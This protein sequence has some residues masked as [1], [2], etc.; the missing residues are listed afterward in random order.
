MVFK[1]NNNQWHKLQRKLSF[2][3]LCWYL[4]MHIS[5]RS[6]QIDWKHILDY[7][8]LHAKCIK[9]PRGMNESR[10]INITWSNICANER[11]ENSWIAGDD[12]SLKKHRRK[13]QM[14]MLFTVLNL[15][16]QKGVFYI[17]WALGDMDMGLWEDLFA[18]CLAQSCHQY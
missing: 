7:N 6:K 3:A 12:I 15:E 9:S 17:N 11:N 1:L 16:I 10:I 8:S 14:H 5:T 13:R 4:P 2:V 18:F